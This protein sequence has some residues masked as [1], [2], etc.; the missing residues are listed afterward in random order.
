MAKVLTT[1]SKCVPNL[2]TLS[3]KTSTINIRSL[4]PIHR[5]YSIEHGRYSS[6]NNNIHSN[7]QNHIS[8]INKNRLL[9][10][11]YFIYHDPIF[12]SKRGN[13]SQPKGFFGSLIDNIKEEFNKNKDIKDN[14]KKFR[15]QAKKLEDSDALKEARDKYVSFY[16]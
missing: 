15:D 8:N 16:V 5:S 3:S 4:S 11:T 13:A 1:A 7:Q 12:I 6:L 9:Q 10:P 2:I 14:I